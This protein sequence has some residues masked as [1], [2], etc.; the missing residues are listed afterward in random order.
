MACRAPHV[1]PMDR[2]KVTLIGLLSRKGGVAWGRYVQWTTR[3]GERIL[4]VNV[5][6]MREAEYIAA[7]E[8]LRQELLKERTMALVL[9]DLTKTRMTTAT[10][11]KAKEVSAATKAA[12]I[13]FRPNAIVGPTRI[14]NSAADLSA[15]KLHFADTVEE[16]KDWLVKQDDL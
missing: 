7:L 8:E 1:L 14:Q 6:G 16:A 12:G 5:A 3:K 4:F 10:V 15:S 13:P 2:N 9:V 11:N